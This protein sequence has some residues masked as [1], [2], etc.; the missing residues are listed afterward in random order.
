M[1]VEEHR[2]SLTRLCASLLG[3]A[4]Q[5]TYSTVVVNGLNQVPAQVAANQA[6]L[7]CVP[8]TRAVGVIDVSGVRAYAIG[9]RA[10]PTHPKLSA[11][12]TFESLGLA[13][14]PAG[15]GYGV[16]A[17]A[18]TPPATEAA[19][20]AAVTRL[21]QDQAWARRLLP[22][23]HAAAA[24]FGQPA[25]HRRYTEEQVMLW[26]KGLDP[27]TAPGVASAQPPALSRPVDASTCAPAQLGSPSG[28]D[29]IVIDVTGAQALESRIDKSAGFSR[30]A[31]SFTFIKPRFPRP[32]L[33]TQFQQIAG[34]PMDPKFYATRE[35]NY[36]APDYAAHRAAIDALPPAERAAMLG[37]L[38][39]H[40][41]YFGRYMGVGALLKAFP[42][43]KAY[44]YVW[45]K[46]VRIEVGAGAGAWNIFSTVRD[47]PPGA[48]CHGSL[49]QFLTSPVQSRWTDAK[50]PDSGE[51]WFFPTLFD[52]GFDP[53]SVRSIVQ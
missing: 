20:N 52:Q 10:R 46:P 27:A 15:N 12:P 35:Y 50:L 36:K 32:E 3:K 17:P 33:L 44:T 8:G 11:L 41:R 18:G 1:A 38:I 4:L 24:E 6:D 30:G 22:G 42:E 39:V 25:A 45:G 13:G 19:I 5:I 47:Q 2:S 16:F 40:A 34:Q 21:A 29:R 9:T 31:D 51:D 48:A 14:L 37:G 43:M 49:E 28:G 23:L 53:H 7:A 26:S